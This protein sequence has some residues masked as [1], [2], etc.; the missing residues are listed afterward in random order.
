MLLAERC[1]TKNFHWVK[2]LLNRG[3]PWGIAARQ[4]TLNGREVHSTGCARDRAGGPPRQRLKTAVDSQI[5]YSPPVPHR[6]ITAVGATSGKGEW[7]RSGWLERA[8]VTSVQV[9]LGMRGGSHAGGT[10]KVPSDPLAANLASRTVAC[11]RAV[12]TSDGRRP[13]AVMSRP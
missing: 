3:V 11:R 12:Q 4:A 6:H 2:A 8:S 5:T 10:D 7:S 13:T 1:T 9:A